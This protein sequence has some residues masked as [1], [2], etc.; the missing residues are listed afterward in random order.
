MSGITDILD[1]LP[2]DAIIFYRDKW[3]EIAN[4]IRIV[5][6]RY[7]GRIQEL[8]STLNA[9]ERENEVLRELIAKHTIKTKGDAV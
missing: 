7:Q 4:N 2:P 9:L 1:H 6:R 5:I 3:D 8:Q